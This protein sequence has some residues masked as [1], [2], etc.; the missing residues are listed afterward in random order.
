MCNIRQYKKEKKELTAEELG[1]CSDSFISLLMHSKN[2]CC[3]LLD[4]HHYYVQR[5]LDLFRF[6]L[7]NLGEETASWTKSCVV[8][9]LNS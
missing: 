4:L 9:L 2:S 1:S 5:I 8:L 6:L 3:S 7:F